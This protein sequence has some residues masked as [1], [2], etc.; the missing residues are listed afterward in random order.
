MKQSIR[1]AVLEGL[2]KELEKEFG[3]H[4]K[5]EI[6]V[7]QGLSKRELEEYGSYQDGKIYLPQKR[8]KKVMR[9]GLMKGVAR[10]LT[11]KR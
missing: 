1:E 8:F 9:R 10:I 2:E 4:T 3:G 6:L 11:G 5:G 7:V